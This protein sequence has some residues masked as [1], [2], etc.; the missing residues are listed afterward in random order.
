MS[1]DR[2][3]LDLT[4]RP[5]EGYRT[6]EVAAAL[7]RLLRIPRKRARNLLRGSPSRIRRE[8]DKER[9]FHLRSK[10]IACGAQCEVT[11]SEN[12]RDG[13]QPIEAG[14]ELNEKLE[15]EINEPE[16]ELGVKPAES[17]NDA[18]EVVLSKPVQS[19]LQSVR[20]VPGVLPADGET[21]THS[22]PDRSTMGS[23]EEVDGA[24][25]SVVGRSQRVLLFA[26]GAALLLGIALWAGLSFLGG[27]APRQQKD[28]A[29]QKPINKVVP[30]AVDELEN[31]RQRLELLASSVKIWM[32]QYGAGFDP[33]QVTMER[34][35]QDLG[36]SPE[37]MMD[38]WGTPFH[39]SSNA[40]SYTLTSAG[41]DR[42]F[43]S[44][45]DIKVEKPSR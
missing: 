38:D 13:Q 12:Q 21:E 26:A 32:I 42:M 9:A 43:D 3:F 44:G 35:Q 10:I 28:V 6:E 7:A 39:Y 37:E 16:F 2:Y 30:K 31:T 33:S 4:G 40:D 1:G 27:S 11:P 24:S 5:L 41:S 23:V 18:E 19:G 20:A 45:D 25:G 17:R 15:L 22:H 14:I 29:A 8:F 36:I 34:M